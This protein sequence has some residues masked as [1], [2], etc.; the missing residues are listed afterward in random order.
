M[1]KIVIFLFLTVFFGVSFFVAVAFFKKNNVTKV[2]T[3]TNITKVTTKLPSQVSV[4]EKYPTQPLASTEL[5]LLSS[6]VSKLTSSTTRSR[7]SAW[8]KPSSSEQGVSL[9]VQNNSNFGHSFYIIYPRKSSSSIAIKMVSSDVRVSSV[10]ESPDQLYTAFIENDTSLYILSNEN[11]KKSLVF[12]GSKDIS[13]SIIDWSPDSAKVLFLVSVHD[14]EDAGGPVYV[15]KYYKIFDI[16]TGFFQTIPA[17]TGVSI[18]NF[19]GNE[20]VIVS[21]WNEEKDLASA[22]NLNLLNVDNEKYQQQY[23][24]VNTVI[25]SDNRYAFQRGGFAKDGIKFSYSIGI[26]GDKDYE[27]RSPGMVSGP[28]I[29]MVVYGDRQSKLTKVL[30]KGWWAQY[31]Q[32]LISPNGDKVIYEEEKHDNTDPAWFFWLYDSV[33]DKQR[34]YKFEYETRLEKWIDN[35]RV[36]M[37]LINSTTSPKTYG[38]FNTVT[39]QMIDVFEKGRLIPELGEVPVKTV[40]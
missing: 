22:I 40:E 20:H 3:V 36:L 13:V 30:A 27:R 1:K 12:R 10:T 28:S 38:V 19:L 39:G 8:K 14:G 7:I 31:Q 11:F 29:D 23:D 18:Q 24:F 33:T 21:I 34:F 35:D 26:T 15:A 4:E 32:S 17:D 2:T 6:A 9:V 25:Q 37:E 5:S 16:D